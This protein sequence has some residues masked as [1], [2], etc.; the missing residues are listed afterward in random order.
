MLRGR[1]SRNL[2][3]PFAKM[4]D[5]LNAH[6]LRIRRA[7]LNKNARQNGYFPG[8][9]MQV[10]SV[11]SHPI[12][13]I[14]IRNLSATTAQPTS[15]IVNESSHRPISIEVNRR[16][17]ATWGIDGSDCIASRAVIKVAPCDRTK[18]RTSARTANSAGLAARNWHTQAPSVDKK[19]IWNRARPNLSG[20]A[21][22]P[23]TATSYSR[24]TIT[25]HILSLAVTNFA[26]TEYSFVLN[27]AACEHRT[28]K[29]R[30]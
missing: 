10:H 12:R 3:A 15:T 21:P 22:R 29:T 13:S 25:V 6:R 8:A 17:L 28:I 19:L 4:V 14:E 18:S 24:N 23:N 27:E 9:R 30:P 16:C 5:Y 26:R 11:V 20:D 1:I 7:R 2:L